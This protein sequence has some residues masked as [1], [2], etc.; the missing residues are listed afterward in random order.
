MK[1]FD[2][3]CP[4]DSLEKSERHGHMP[5]HWQFAASTHE[6]LLEALYPFTIGA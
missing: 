1:P 4:V 2:G 6:W 5:H 3:M